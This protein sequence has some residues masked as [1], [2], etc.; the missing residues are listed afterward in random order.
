MDYNKASKLIEIMIRDF[1]I[2]NNK[3]P[4]EVIIS[5]DIFESIKNGNDLILRKTDLNDIDYTIFGL[6]ITID[7]QRKEIIKVAR[8]ELIH[9]TNQ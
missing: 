1:Y 9:T 2:N 4:N 5:R 6:S 7:E 8:V 3:F